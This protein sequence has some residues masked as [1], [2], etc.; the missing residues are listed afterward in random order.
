MDWTQTF[1][2]I[3]VIGA[4]IMYMIT[5]MERQMDAK[6][7]QMD[8]KIEAFRIELK[9][10][11]RD[12]KSDIDRRFTDLKTDMNQRFSDVNQRL[13]TLEGYLVPKKIFHIE[14]P[15]RDEPK[16]N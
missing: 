12:M 2:I 4:F 9:E 11:M 16:E 1:T 15:P 7:G 5:R 8:A 10:D 13:S 3:G 14:E 6:F